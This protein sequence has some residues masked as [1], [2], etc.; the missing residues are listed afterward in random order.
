[1]LQL[2]QWIYMQL[3]GTP[4]GWGWRLEVNY[5]PVIFLPLDLP[6]QNLLVCE[7]VITVTDEYLA[8]VSHV[9][10]WTKCGVPNTYFDWKH[11]QE[12]FFGVTVKEDTK[13]TLSVR[14]G[15]FQ[16]VQTD[17]LN[18]QQ[19][20]RLG[21]NKQKWRSV[22]LR[23]MNINSSSSIS[24]DEEEPYG[25]NMWRQCVLNWKIWRMVPVFS[26]EDGIVT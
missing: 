4:W 12:M 13:L 6:L 20:W 18:Q 5:W 17:Q 25:D 1:M 19:L 11:P 22:S 23:E 16:W 10:E 21:S 26:T 24:P 7:Y 9:T 15:S 14:E 8:G 3:S 2:L